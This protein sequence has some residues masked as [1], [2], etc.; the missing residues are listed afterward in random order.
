MCVNISAQP[1]PCSDSVVYLNVLKIR[2]AYR[3]IIVDQQKIIVLQDS[4]IIAK[5]A[6]Y[7]QT[8]V[9]KDSAAHKLRVAAMSQI[10]D[11]TNQNT[12]LR[13]KNKI[14]TGLGIAGII[15]TLIFK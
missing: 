12:K 3:N 8:I 11:I 7:E 14:I 13:R 15:L 4:L 10:A 6:F 1:T 2:Q 5:T 9:Q